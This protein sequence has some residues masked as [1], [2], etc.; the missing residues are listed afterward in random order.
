MSHPSWLRVL[1]SLV[2]VSL[3]TVLNEGAELSYNF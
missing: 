3:L 2:L 1:V